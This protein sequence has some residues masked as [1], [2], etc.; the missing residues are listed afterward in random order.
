MVRDYTKW[1]VQEALGW[2]EFENICTAYLYCQH[3]YRDIRQAGRVA[4]QVRDAVILHHDYH[5]RIV[6][7]FSKEQSPLSRPMAKF[8]RDYNRWRGQG[9]QRFVFVSS[10]DL[11]SGKIDVPRGLDDPPVTIFDINDLV[12]FLDYTPEGHEV[13]RQHGI[14][15]VGGMEPQPPSIGDEIPPPASRFSVLSLEDVSHAAAKRYT[16][17]ILIP[18]IGSRAAVRTLVAEAVA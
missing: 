9:L 11:R 5:E 6:F 3:G 4:D 18:P 10:Q 15:I 16:A 14:E 8:F 1:A 2:Q 7:A 17:N 12:L 13:K